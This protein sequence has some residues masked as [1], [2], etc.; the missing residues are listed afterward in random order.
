MEGIYSRLKLL[1]DEKGVALEL[2]CDEVICIN[3]DPDRL[4]QIMINLLSNALK[5]TDRGGSVQ[6]LVSHG[7]GT[8]IEVRDSGK[9][10]SKED[11]PFIFERF[12]RGEKGGLGIGLTI[13]REL[14]EA[15]GGRIEVQSERN[16]GTAFRVELPA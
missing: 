13:V 1:F 6:I 2:V 12:Y 8:V 5:A 16:A 15:H 10:I 7:A 3:A 14:V 4:S 9:G 11:L